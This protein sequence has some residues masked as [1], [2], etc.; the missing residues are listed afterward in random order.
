MISALITTRKTALGGRPLENARRIPTTCFPTA[1]DPAILSVAWTA[2]QT[3]LPGPAAESARQTP[4]TCSSSARFHANNAAHPALPRQR[5][6]VA[7][8]QRV[9]VALRQRV[10][11][12]LP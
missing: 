6:A 11:E 9:A 4:T 7:L 1:L 5:V 2:T 8:R 12:A 3:A 10:A